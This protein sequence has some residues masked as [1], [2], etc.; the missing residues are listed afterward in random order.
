MSENCSEIEQLQRRA[1]Q[2][3]PLKRATEPRR[4]VPYCIRNKKVTE[5]V[6]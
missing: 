5:S 4:E 2:R 6:L 3:T 1:Y